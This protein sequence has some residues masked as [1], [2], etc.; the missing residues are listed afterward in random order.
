[1]LGRSWGP[2]I[3][4]AGDGN[5]SPG[6]F[7]AAASCPCTFL[8]CRPQ[9]HQHPSPEGGKD[10]ACGRGAFGEVFALGLSTGTQSKVAGCHRAIA[11]ARP[12]GSGTRSCA[13][14]RPGGARASR[15]APELAHGR[16]VLTLESPC[17][18]APPGSCV[19]GPR[20][21]GWVAIVTGYFRSLSLCA[22]G[23]L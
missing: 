17:H 13:V 12:R 5:A 7:G 4:G 1:M 8:P 15:C 18:A 19:R 3:G 20:A 21:R 6:A 14:P 10:V 16:E 22:R 23:L 9:A 2:G 11:S